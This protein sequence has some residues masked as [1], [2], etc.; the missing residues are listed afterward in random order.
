MFYPVSALLYRCKANMQNFVEGLP[1]STERG[2]NTEQKYSHVL[3]VQRWRDAVWAFLLFLSTLCISCFQI[4]LALCCVLLSATRL[5][6]LSSCHSNEPKVQDPQ[7]SLRENK[8]LAQDSHEDND[9]CKSGVA[10]KDSKL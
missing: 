2:R 10:H 9:G 1:Q 3:L 4:I 8:Y 5:A 7:T 6:Q